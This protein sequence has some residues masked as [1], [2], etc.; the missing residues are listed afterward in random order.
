MLGASLGA[1]KQLRISALEMTGARR[2][3]QGDRSMKGAG[4]VGQ[5]PVIVD[6]LGNIDPLPNQEIPETKDT[7]VT[8]SQVGTPFTGSPTQS[9]RRRAEGG[10]SIGPTRIGVHPAQLGGG[11]ERLN[12]N[13]VLVGGPASGKGTQAKKLVEQFGLIHI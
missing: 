3:C 9:S 13:L 4:G 11:G 1:Q 5:R 7:F 8:K 12:I 2:P 6:P 10:P